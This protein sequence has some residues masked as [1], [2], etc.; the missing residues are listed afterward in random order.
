MAS[1]GQYADEEARVLA[2][3]TSPEEA[4]PL[5]ASFTDYVKFNEAAAKSIELDKKFRQLERQRFEA[6]ASGAEAWFGGWHYWTMDVGADYQIGAFKFAKNVRLVTRDLILGDSVSGGTTASKYF[7]GASRDHS[8]MKS[9]A[10]VPGA[11][12]AVYNDTK[13]FLVGPGYSSRVTDAIEA[14][15][16]FLR[17]GWFPLI[18]QQELDAE[19]RWAPEA[20]QDGRDSAFFWEVNAEVA[21]FTVDV[22]MTMQS[23]RAMRVAAQG[24]SH[25]DDVHYVQTGAIHRV[26][27]AGFADLD[28]TGVNLRS[29]SSDKIRITDRGIDVVES[30]LS[31]FMRPDGRPF[32][33]NTVMLRD[34]RKIAAGKLEATK[35]HRDFYAHE[36][37]EF[38]RFRAKGY[39]TGMPHKGIYKNAHYATLKEY[40]IPFD[41][42]ADYLLTP[43]AQSMLFR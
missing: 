33:S 1:T 42:Q 28:N 13:T 6:N 26:G 21:L 37:R 30:H 19:G 5:T 8:L 41:D 9:A 20:Y 11:V 35:V 31:R 39:S 40:A 22:G 32:G 17:R 10:G 24:L 12:D 38:V 4:H 43:A 2:E 36:L 23:A 18:I 27:K 7:A 29:L 25:L 15:N 16:A 14:H 34:L 3:A